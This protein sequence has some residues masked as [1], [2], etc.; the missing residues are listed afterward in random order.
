MAN[1]A[2]I[3]SARIQP[4]KLVRLSKHGI[5]TVTLALDNDESGRDALARAIDQTSRFDHAPALRVVHPADLGDAKDPDEYVRRHGVH[6]FRELVRDAECGVTWRTFDRMRHLE[7]KSPQ[8]ERRAALADVGSWLGTLPPRLALEV[9]DAILAASKRSGY[10]PEA[11]ERAFH[12][13]FWSAGPGKRERE[14]ALH[15]TR[16]CDHPIDL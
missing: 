14:A 6:R 11:V 1:V 5:E 10:D 3:G 7:P 9:E 16:Q 2:A 15:P 8:R 4:E 12:A 13:K